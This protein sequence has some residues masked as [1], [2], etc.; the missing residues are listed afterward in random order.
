MIQGRV[1]WKELVADPHSVGWGGLPGAGGSKMTL[2]IY[3][4]SYLGW[5][6]CLGAGWTS[7]YACLSS[8]SKLPLFTQW[9]YPKRA[10]AETVRPL[11]TWALESQ[12]VVSILFSWSKQVTNP[13]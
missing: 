3:L 6:E 9:L 7:L 5:Q 13:R 11:K 8:F 4:A 10:K 1:W 12:N 2:L